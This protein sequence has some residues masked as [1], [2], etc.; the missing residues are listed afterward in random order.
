LSIRLTS[1][2]VTAAVD[3]AAGGR[4]A[5]IVIAGRERLVTEPDPSATL[6]AITW[7][8]FAMLPWVGRMRGGRLDWRGTSAQLP[9]D[10]GAHAIHGTTYDQPWDV[11][12]ADERSVDLGCRLGRS[13]RWPFAAEARQRIDLRSDAISLRIEVRAEEPMPVAAG[14]HPWFRREADE[15]LIVT[16]PAPTVLETTDDLIPTG[17]VIPVDATTD[18]RGSHEIGDRRLDHAYVGVEG[19][20]LIVWPDLELTIEA[21]PL[22]SVV[23]YSPA[24]SICL[25]PESAWPDAIHLDG[26]G[27][28][29]GLVALAAG[30]TFRLETRWSW[31]ASGGR[32]R[33]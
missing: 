13:E 25:E 27:L 28:P 11:L 2:E 16:V 14:W 10:F 12:A 23:V 33:S 20:C 32:P 21:Q 31:R 22:G 6:P 29:A 15:P 24:G 5:S 8:S 3:P 7:G 18:L 9:R 30:E 1:G 17:S 26:L 4:L 19:P